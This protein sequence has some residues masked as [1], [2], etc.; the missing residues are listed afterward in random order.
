MFIVVTVE[1]KEP[2]RNADKIF[3]CEWLVLLTLDLRS[4]TYFFTYTTQLEGIGAR[5]N[6]SKSTRKTAIQVY[7]DV[8]K[9]AST[10]SQFSQVVDHECL[11]IGKARATTAAK[12]QPLALYH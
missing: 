4:I 10:L 7:I 3:V 2:N 12:S 1:E 5:E 6:A 11:S 9:I 8:K